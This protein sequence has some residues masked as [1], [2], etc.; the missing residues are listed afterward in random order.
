MQE[1]SFDAIRAQG[2]GGQKV[3]KVSTAVHLRFDIVASSLPQI[4][5]SRLLAARDR[6]I[7]AAGILVIKAQ[8]HRSREQNKLD[9]LRRLSSIVGTHTAV[10][11]KRKLS[12][13]SI[14]AKKRRVAEKRSRGKLKMLRSR[15]GGV[16]D[17]E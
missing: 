13:P 9:A 4:Y 16:T 7:S 5:K 10:A 17:V 12:R 3:N 6:R 2:S 8:R 15:G 14:T 11:T 1:V